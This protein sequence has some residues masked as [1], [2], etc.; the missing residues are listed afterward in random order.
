MRL[1]PGWF[2]AHNDLG[3]AL[4]E[5][6]DLRAAAECYLEALRIE[7]TYIDARIHLG[8]LFFEVDQFDQAI[9]EYQRA[10][11]V[12]PDH[13]GANYHLGAALTLAGRLDEALPAFERAL[14]VQPEWPAA[15]AGLAKVLAQHPDD[16]VRNPAAAV[17]LAR[18]AAELTGFQN[19]SILDA[20][21]TAYAAAGRSDSAAQVRRRLIDLRPQATPGQ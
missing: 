12:N 6:G 5:Q 20:L 3:L 14:R 21:A 4:A 18:R 7:P 8:H 1:R 17:A 2:T 15:L 11:R 13:A 19:R 10:L 16:T 9:A